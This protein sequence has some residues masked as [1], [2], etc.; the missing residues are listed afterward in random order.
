MDTTDTVAVGAS[1]F[2]FA[3]ITGFG[4]G[5]TD[6][7]IDFIFPPIERAFQSFI[8][9]PVGTTSS[10][11]SYLRNFRLARRSGPRELAYYWPRSIR[12]G[13]KLPSIE[14]TRE[15]IQDDKTK[16]PLPN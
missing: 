13:D 10:I 3:E 12:E 8:P 11:S 14:R 4:R 1:L 5:F 2:A 6:T 15:E 9:D 7:L 16:H